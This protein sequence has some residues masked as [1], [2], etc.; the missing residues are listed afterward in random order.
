MHIGQIEEFRIQAEKYL[1]D[2]WPP[3]PSA[4][5]SDS[6]Q[7]AVRMDRACLYTSSTS[8]NLIQR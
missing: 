8:I 4:N 1:K 3:G 6:V 2:Q 5:K 7:A